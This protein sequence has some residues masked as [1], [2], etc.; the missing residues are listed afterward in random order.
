MSVAIA[1]I[2]EVSGQVAVKTP[3]GAVRQLSVG[4]TLFVGEELITGENGRVSLDFGDSVPMSFG[5]NQTL[6]LTPNMQV[7]AE[8]ATQESALLD[9]SVEAVLTALENG[10]DL[11]EELEAPAAG[12]A[13]A[14]TGGGGSFVLLTRVA[15]EVDPQSF[16]FG[17][18]PVELFE[19]EVG[20][21][22]QDAQIDTFDGTGT[23][24]DITASI[25]IDP[26]AGDDVINAAEA[27]QT[28][29]TVTGTVGDDVQAGDEVTLTV[30]G[31]D[32]TGAV[33]DDGNGNLS[34][35]IEVTTADLVADN[36]V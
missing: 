7:S 8:P 14:P 29:T 17:I 6:Q 22:Q 2:T 33:V 27:A 28:V 35:S 13:G 1:V 11:L 32:F 23:D 4:D 30:N 12:L 3:D 26:I 31:N 36:T 34:Y 20:A 25:T 15:E 16:E 19:L 10:D 24:T 5:E 18:A 9:P 21:V